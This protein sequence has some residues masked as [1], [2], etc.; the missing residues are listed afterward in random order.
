MD[1]NSSPF[2]YSVEAFRAQESMTTYAIEAT[3]FNSEVVFDLRG[4]LEAKNDQK[5]NRLILPQNR[6]GQTSSAYVA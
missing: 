5:L 3:E 2:I 6:R 4:C 1:D